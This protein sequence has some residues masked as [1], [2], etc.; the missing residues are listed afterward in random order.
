MDENKHKTIYIVLFSVFFFTAMIQSIS[1]VFVA[2]EM[3]YTDESDDLYLYIPTTLEPESCKSGLTLY[4]GYDIINVKVSEENG[5]YHFNTTFNGDVNMMGLSIMLFFDINGTYASY[6]D[7]PP[8]DLDYNFFVKVSPDSNR[9]V[10][11]YSS[12]RTTDPILHNNIMIEMTLDA[13]DNEWILSTPG[14]LPM[15]QWK[16]F[17]YSTFETASGDVWD[18]VNWPWR[19]SNDLLRCPGFPV[20]GIVLIVL[21]S[22]AVAGVVIVVVLNKKGIDIRDYLRKYVNKDASDT[23]TT[24][25]DAKN[26]S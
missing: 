12:Q 2:A 19:N 15:S 4:P 5:N 13:S 10:F 20:W 3:T 17:G 22:I 14:L 1:T 21:G 11:S 7:I 6:E 16:M 18:Y 9:I 23:R 24:E 25:E 26:A 8:Y